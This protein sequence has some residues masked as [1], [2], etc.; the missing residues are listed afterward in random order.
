MA[1]IGYRCSSRRDGRSG[2]PDAPSSSS[3]GISG[4]GPAKVAGAALD[5]G[6]DEAERIGALSA[7]RLVLFPSL[8]RFAV[9]IP[10]I[11]STTSK[12]C[13]LYFSH[14]SAPGRFC[15]AFTGTLCQRAVVT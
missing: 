1:F 7:G 15:I 10:G 9:L 4:G 2:D 6:V 3:K 12:G 13:R 5:P 8:F 11:S 14:L